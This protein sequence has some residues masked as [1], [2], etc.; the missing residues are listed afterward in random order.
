[1]AWGVRCAQLRQR[2]GL[3]IA[4]AV[5]LGCASMFL[6][7]KAIEYTHKWDI[8]LLPAGAYETQ[9]LP[10]AHHEGLSPWL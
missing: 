4:L 9:S 8:G 7:V 6:G 5:T 2:T 3:V 10:L 1:M